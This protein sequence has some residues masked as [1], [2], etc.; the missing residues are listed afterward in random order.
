MQKIYE[1][2]DFFSFGVLSKRD[3]L[4][5]L[6]IYA[7]SAMIYVI[8]IMTTYNALET[9][10]CL[11]IIDFFIW[12]YILIY[13]MTTTTLMLFVYYVYINYI[14]VYTIDGER[15]YKIYECG[16]FAYIARRVVDG[17]PSGRV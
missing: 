14:F 2:L 4:A 8:D 12:G 17:P 13:Y 7:Q 15:S 10:I 9:S 3:F 11:F 5:F 16:Q 1:D 6:A